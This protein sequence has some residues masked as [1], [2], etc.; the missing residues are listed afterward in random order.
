VIVATFASSR[1]LSIKSLAR[2]STAKQG[3]IQQL[4][5]LKICPNKDFFGSLKKN[6]LVENRKSI[7]FFNNLS[8]ISLVFPLSAALLRSCRKLLDYS[9][10]GRVNAQRIGKIQKEKTV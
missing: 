5:V 9:I 2:K 3:Q 7:L 8:V 6:A 1:V 4:N 10:L